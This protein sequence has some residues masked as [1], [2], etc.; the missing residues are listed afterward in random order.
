MIFS[1]EI[2]EEFKESLSQQNLTVLLLK[3]SLPTAA[4]FCYSPS[5]V[6]H[7]YNVPQFGSGN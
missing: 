3:L 7:I 1:L 2:S 6:C 5:N 4:S